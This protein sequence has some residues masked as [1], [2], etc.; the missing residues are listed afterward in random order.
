MKTSL[1]AVNFFY[2]YFSF[3]YFFFGKVYFGLTAKRISM[4]CYAD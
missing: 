4:M 2:N 3:A 1:L